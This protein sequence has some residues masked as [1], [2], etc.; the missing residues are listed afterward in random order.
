MGSRFLNFLD[1]P[2]TDRYASEVQK[3]IHEAGNPF[4]DWFFGGVE[5]AR[6]TVARRIIRPTSEVSLTRVKVLFEGE[7]SAGGFL[8]LSGKELRVCRK[9]DMLSLMADMKFDKSFDLQGRFAA[10]R[11]LFPHVA[12]DAYYLSKIWVN[13]AFRGKG[14]G[15][16]IL[17]GFL[18]EGR[19]KGFVSFRLDVAANNFPAIRLYRSCGFQ[20]LRQSFSARADQHYLSMC[21]DLSE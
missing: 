8:C 6:K 17:Q 12:E 21:L 7:Q 1:I 9:I 20:I 5:T 4:H 3:G 10:A 13:P 16:K 2:D 11:E 14:Y 15:W 19:G 18:G